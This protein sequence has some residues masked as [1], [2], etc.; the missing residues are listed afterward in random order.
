M[1]HSDKYDQKV[2]Q[3]LFGNFLKVLHI[4]DALDA[5]HYAPIW[6]TLRQKSIVWMFY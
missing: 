2:A 6:I 5:F 3:N 4:M 1:P